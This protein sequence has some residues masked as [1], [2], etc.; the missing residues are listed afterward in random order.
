[1]ARSSQDAHMTSTN[2]RRKTTHVEAKERILCMFY[3]PFIYPI[4]AL[5]LA[6]KYFASLNVITD[7]SLPS[8]S[9]R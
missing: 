7:L 8:V 3:L 5:M 9:G 6:E 4:P 1:M 2:A